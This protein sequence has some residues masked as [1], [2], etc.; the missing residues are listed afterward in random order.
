MC[1]SI[2]M[3]HSFILLT[4]NVTVHMPNKSFTKVFQ[5]SLISLHPK[6]SLHNTLFVSSFHYNL[7]SIS[8][9]LRTT[10]MKLIFYPSY[11]LFQGQQTKEVI[12]LGKMLARLYKVDRSSLSTSV[13]FSVL[14]DIGH[15]SVNATLFEIHANL[16]KESTI[17]SS[18][19]Q[20]NKKLLH[21]RLGN[22]SW[23]K[24]KHIK[25]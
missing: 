14:N 11:C 7:L 25:G 24:L 1:P 20:L 17:C 6:L 8:K 12:A 4:Q 19:H 21:F 22:A 16:N 9:L 13:I 18:T 5:S 10:N 23:G 15:I 3:F 2:S